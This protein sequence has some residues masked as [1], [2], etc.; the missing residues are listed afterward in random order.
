[1]VTVQPLTSTAKIV[2]VRSLLG[3]G[4][5]A[6]PGLVKLLHDRLETQLYTAVS[7]GKTGPKILFQNSFRVL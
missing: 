4:E 2:A 7:K 5:D 6:K 1:M 3:F